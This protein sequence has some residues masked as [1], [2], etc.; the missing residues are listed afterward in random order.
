MLEKSRPLKESSSKSSRRSSKS[1]ASTKSS[2]SRKSGDSKT[3]AIEEETKLA[4]PLAE[5]SFL[6]KRQIAENEAERMKVQEMLAKAKAE[7]Y[8]ESVSGDGKIFPQTEEARPSKQTDIDHYFQKGSHQKLIQDEHLHPKKTDIADVLCNLVKQQSAT[9]VELDVF[10]GNHLDYHYFMILFDELGEK[11]I[12]DPRG[13]LNLLIKYT[14][15][16]PKEMIKHCVQQCAAVGYDN[17][18]KLLQQKY[19]NPYSLMS[20]Y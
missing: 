9:D 20:M 16:N 19:G 6:M 12:K 4:E 13:R 8:E 14:E 5:E 3:K 18:K 17:A 11:R 10:D 2:R 7:V 15:G 1:N